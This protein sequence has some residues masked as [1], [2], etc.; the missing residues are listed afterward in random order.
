MVVRFLQGNRFSSA[1]TMEK[2]LPVIFIFAT[3]DK[4][5]ADSG[6]FFPVIIGSF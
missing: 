5:F 4:D 6:V 1:I 3:Y 2:Q